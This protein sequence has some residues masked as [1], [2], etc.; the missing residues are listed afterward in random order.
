VAGALAA[1][2]LAGLY[3]FPVPVGWLLNA[4]LDL[5]LPRGSPV[6][7]RLGSADFRWRPGREQCLLTVRGIAISGQGGPSAAIAELAVEM[8]KAGFLRLQ[9]APS[10]M[11]VKGATAALD[12][13]AK[14]NSP[15]SETGIG[16]ATALD[17]AA[18]S[19]FLPHQGRHSI[20]DI[21]GFTLRLRLPS[22]ETQIRF[23][24]ATA[25]LA[26]TDGGGLRG[27]LSIPIGAG[28]GSGRIAGEASLAPASQDLVFSLKAPRFATADVL[29]FPGEQSFKGEIAID[30]NGEFN[31]AQGRLLKLA[32]AV[33][34]ADSQIELPGAAQPIALPLLDLRGFIDQ[35]AGRA[36]LESGR[37][38]FAGAELNVSE[39]EADLGSRPSVRWQARLQR[40]QGRVLRELAGE[41][42]QLHLPSPAAL[43]DDMADIEIAT[44]GR[45]LLARNAGGSWAAASVSAECSASARI[46]AES[47]ALQMTALQ[48][49]G[50]E[51]VLM[52]AELAPIHP[53]LLPPLWQQTMGFAGLDAPVTL[54]A[55]ASIAP[56]GALASLAVDLR[57]GSGRLPAQ[58]P[59]ADRLKLQSI[60]A[61]FESESPASSWRL[62]RFRAQF[63]GGPTLALTDAD[64][65][66]AP[67]RVIAQGLARLDG[68]D[69]SLIGSWL[70]SGALARLSQSGVV[71]GDLTFDQAQGRVRIEAVADPK[72]AWIPG[73]A[74]AALACKLHVQGTP[75]GV[76]AQVSVSD[77]KAA[78]FVA[79]ISEFRPAD[80]KATLPGGMPAR[81]FDFP[82]AVRVSAHAD[83]GRGLTDLGVH[84]KA[85]AGVL[86][87]APAS[88][89]EI[90][91]D[92]ASLDAS[93]SPG[94]GSVRVQS[95]HLDSKRMHLQIEDAVS[96]I[97]P[98]YRTSGRLRLSAS[99]LPPLVALCG[100][101]PDAGLCGWLASVLQD[102]RIEGAS[103][104]WAA[105]YDPEKPAGLSIGSLEGQVHLTGLRAALGQIPAPLAV[106]DLAL[107]IDY[108]KAGAEATGLSLPGISL[109]SV[110]VETEALGTPGASFT[111][112]V[113]L[114][115]DLPIASRLWPLPDAAQ[116]LG[117]AGVDASFS[118]LL[119]GGKL[120][121]RFAVDLAKGRIALPGVSD[122]APDAFEAEMSLQDF[123]T[124]GTKSKVAFA[125]RAPHWFGEPLDAEGRLDFAPGNFQLA[126]VEFTRFQHGTSSLTASFRVA[127]HGHAFL[128]VAGSRIDAAPWLRAM[129]AASDAF[130]AAA[131]PAQANSAGARPPAPGSPYPA[132]PGFL[133]A[134]VE[135]GDVVMGPGSDVRDLKLVAHLGERGSSSLSLDATTGAGAKL[136]ATLTDSGGEQSVKLRLDNAPAWAAVLAAPWRGSGLKSGGLAQRMARIAELPSIVSGG[137][138]AADAV[139]VPGADTWFKGRLQ[140]TN[141][142][143][144]RAPRIMQLL[145]LKSRHSLQSAPLVDELTLDKITIDRKQLRVG[146]FA[147]RGSGFTRH[148]KLDKAS[149][150]LADEQLEIEGGFYGVGFV[151]SGALSDPEVFLKENS[152]IRAVGHPNE[153]DFDEP[154]KPD[155]EGPKK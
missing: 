51:S 60:E 34:I 108:P 7:M 111:A 126:G 45:A 150:G 128:Q 56:T 44:R 107:T 149:Y 137:S 23:P 42:P 22:G 78:E 97:A 85:R 81:D 5:S 94:G 24:H 105:A 153:F 112:A 58:M 84:V 115:A 29:S 118:G 52:T 96:S 75:L 90:P 102:G 33:Q 144:A 113:H 151:V 79:D 57:A 110:R 63:A 131:R 132:E 38:Q 9:F 37:I 6:R 50:R 99:E 16:V 133:D 27:D 119:S 10:R 3:L 62:P 35:G 19:R 77:A 59:G 134:D 127:A 124:P 87:L 2:F 1:A 93:C 139:L 92:S 20:L 152:F 64:V 138:I 53:N 43:L 30:L 25:E 12:L 125:I 8:P 147:L 36:R 146:E 13:A 61:R 104:K 98:P 74:S 14:E 89:L 72:G 136:H 76:S 40:A 130:S 70:P 95:F 66:F 71:P 145:A 148:L 140:L 32:G 155:Q 121:G 15:P 123:N 106:R 82:V 46:G 41:L 135:C 55:S 73:E 86:R 49:E 54:S 141:T 80:L 47:A 4:G 100:E 18:A 39:L 91:L 26:P 31:L 83:P 120:K 88:P 48:P 28:A 101:S 116:F 11:T 142:T 17:Q 68:I 117:R 67:G 21:D 109:P 69:G 154:D 65:R 129:V 143:L 103:L 114:D 122:I